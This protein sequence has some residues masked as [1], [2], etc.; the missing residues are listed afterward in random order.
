MN[1]LISPEMHE[2]ARTV[3]EA[4]RVAEAL[5]VRRYYVKALQEMRRAGV[6]LKEVEHA[7]EIDRILRKGLPERV[8]AEI[9]D[10]SVHLMRQQMAH[11]RNEETKAPP[12]SPEEV[13]EWERR[14]EERRRREAS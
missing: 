14:R 9:A 13:E 6:N 8:A 10:D 12:P 7:K 4:N 5:R 1:R 3:T 11:E 2:A